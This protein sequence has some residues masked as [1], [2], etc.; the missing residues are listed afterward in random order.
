VLFRSNEVLTYHYERHYER[1]ETDPRI[2]HALTLEV[3]E[4]GNVLRSAAIGYGRRQLDPKLS[5]ADQARQ[6]QILITYTENGV[7][8]DHDTDNAA[9][10]RGDDY[11]IPLPCESRTYELTGV[12]E[13]QDDYPTALE[14]Y[15]GPKDRARFTFDE[16]RDAGTKAFPI[17]YEKDPTPGQLEKRLI[18]HVRTYYRR[19]DLSGPLPLGK[20]QSL[21]LPFESYKLA[22]T[23]GLISEVYGLRATDD[24][25][26]N[27]G[28]YVHTEDDT[29]WWIPSG[30]VFFSPTDDSAAQELAYARQHFFLPHR[31]RD[32]FHTPA[33][34]TESFVA[35]DT[36][37]LL[38]HE[39]RDALGNRVT[40]GERAWLLPDGMQLPEKRRNDYRVL[41]PALVM[42]PNRNCSAVA[43]DALGM[44]VGSAVMG[45]P[46]ENPRPGDL[47]DDLFQR[48]LTQD[49]I[50]RFMGNPRTAS[51]NPNESV[52]TQVT[53][54]L[55]G[56]ATTRIV[57]DLDRF[58][59]LG[60][61]PFAATI[62][63]ETHVSDLQGHSKSKLQTSFSYSDGFGR[64]IQQKIQAEAGPVPQRDA[65]GKIVVVDGQPVMT[66]GDFRPR[67]VGS[68]WTV[69]NNKGKP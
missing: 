12:I 42:D 43:F 54:D 2:Q 65:D 18:E 26:A 40:I 33:V 56:Q 58:K 39:T 36:Y 46:E 17:D 20:L 34:S 30:R 1:D 4:F 25:L 50:D 55:L 15:F 61:P 32:P 11:R 19:N 31:Y 66:D 27:E 13:W 16:I 37:D 62:A 68:G 21:A 23:P 8:K 57:Y 63:R 69:F 48:D 53:H 49:Q 24:M 64:E 51:A 28:R 3:D 29:T 5:P 14:K 45:K 41:Q 52:A 38:V 10:D 9:I 6:A 35:Y 60:E 44:V 22:F 67:W 7:T 59:R 47:L